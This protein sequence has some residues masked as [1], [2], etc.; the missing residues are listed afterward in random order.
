[1]MFIAIQS[2]SLS[3][4]VIILNLINS[5]TSLNIPPPLHRYTVTPLQV[6]QVLH[7]Y[8]GVTGV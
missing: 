4:N 1:M 3:L 7:R 6:L 2:H 5:L 8:R